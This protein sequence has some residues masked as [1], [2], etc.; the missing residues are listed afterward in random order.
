[1]PDPVTFLVLLMLNGAAAPAKPAAAAP[2]PAAVEQPATQPHS[3]TRRAAPRSVAGEA[4]GATDVELLL[5][6]HGQ[7]PTG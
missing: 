7:R 5:R 2:A 4:A 1:M 6:L 3:I